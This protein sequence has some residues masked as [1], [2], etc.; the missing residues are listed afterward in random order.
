MNIEIMFYD[1]LSKI[2]FR[3]RFFTFVCLALACWFQNLHAQ[4]VLM[5]G[6]TRVLCVYG[7]ARCYKFIA[8]LPRGHD[9]GAV[10]TDRVH[11][12]VF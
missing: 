2:R 1:M 4:L 3:R 8:K 11:R 5:R 7:R 10:S 9:K 12:V 6:L